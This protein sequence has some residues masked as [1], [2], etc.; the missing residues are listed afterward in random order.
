V[1]LFADWLEGDEGE[2]PSPVLVL[3]ERPGSRATCEQQIAD[4]VVDNLFGL[5]ILER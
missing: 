3:R 2:G 1:P 5:E 4:A